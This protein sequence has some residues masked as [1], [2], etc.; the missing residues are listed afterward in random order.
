MAPV[1]SC[2]LVHVVGDV[3]FQTSIFGRALTAFTVMVPVV[4]SHVTSAVSPVASS[5]TSLLAPTHASTR[6]G[7][8]LVPD[9]WTRTPFSVGAFNTL[10]VQPLRASVPAVTPLL[11]SLEKAPD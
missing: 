1:G 11:K 3:C 10:A 6:A 5:L 8:G 9:T 2:A 4:G 7:C